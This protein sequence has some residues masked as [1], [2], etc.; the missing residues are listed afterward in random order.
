MHPLESGNGYAL[1]MVVENGMVYSD[2]TNSLASLGHRYLPH[3]AA[4]AIAFW[5]GADPGEVVHAIPSAFRRNGHSVTV[6]MGHVFT[7]PYHIRFTR[8]Q[9]C[10]RCLEEL[11]FA[12]A[13]WE[14]SL[15]TAC[16]RHHIGLVDQC[17]RCH[18]M[19]SWRR[20]NL[21]TCHCGADFSSILPARATAEAVWLSQRL[22]DLLVRRFVEYD[23]H[24][25]VRRILAAF[26]LDVLLRVIRAFGVSVGTGERDMVP[27]RL[28]RVLRSEDANAVV[29]RAF[30]RLRSVATGITD[31]PPCAVHLKE[32][33]SLAREAVDHE[34]AM[35]MEVLNR[36]APTD[37][38]GRNSRAEPTQL[39][40][41]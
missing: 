17:T 22:E 34:E 41:F 31:E 35:L 19:I 29:R 10:I 5:F 30:S 39:R 23:G 25:L 24:E 7:R 12:S 38:N 37:A 21:W 28:T 36:V 16:P 3:S 9:V 2:L 1:R 18:R 8:P 26:E 20:P 11:G 32:L 40:L 14:L 6:F 4:R 15:V 13:V 27:G 33:R